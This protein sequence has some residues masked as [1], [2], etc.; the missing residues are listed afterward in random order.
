MNDEV[1]DINELLTVINNIQVDTLY[2]SRGIQLKVGGRKVTPS[3]FNYSFKTKIEEFFF[4][5]GSFFLG[6]F[7]LGG[8]L[9]P[10]P[11]PIL[12]YSVKE[13]YINSA[14]S[15]ILCHRH[16]HRGEPY[17]LSGYRDPS[18]QTNR[19]THI[20]LLYYTNYYF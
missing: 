2:V 11:W 20:L 12:S 4:G 1:T 14:V 18:V 17:R 13:N 19:Q 15:E 3:T 7:L 5:G 8:W 6:R 16:T 10:P 9:Y